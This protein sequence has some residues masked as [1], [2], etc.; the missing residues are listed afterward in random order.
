M[1]VL[2]VKDY[3]GNP[4]ENGYRS[5]HLIVTVPVFFSD[6]TKNVPVEIQIRTIAM[7]FWASLEHQMKY[8]SNEI[9]N[10]D[11]IVAELKACSEDIFA[12]D[13]KM[14]AIRIDIEDRKTDDSDEDVIIEKL[15]RL[16]SE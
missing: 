12:T 3:I 16:T 5:L 8:K 4:K 13:K 9:D 1:E 14:Q 2:N 7:D 11:R 10:S 15:K 6:E